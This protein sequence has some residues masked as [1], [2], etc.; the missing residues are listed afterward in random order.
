MEQPEGLVKLGEEHLVCRFKK[1]LYGLMQAPRQW[2]KRFDSY[3]LKIGYQKLR[4]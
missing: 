2:Y 3:M 4:V 1:S